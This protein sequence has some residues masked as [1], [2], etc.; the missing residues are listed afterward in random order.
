MHILLLIG[1]IAECGSA[2]K[3]LG[4]INTRS[5][6]TNRCI[7]IHLYLFTHSNYPK[8]TDLSRSPRL[9]GYSYPKGN[10]IDHVSI[11]HCTHIMLYWL[12]IQPA[13]TQTRHCKLVNDQNTAVLGTKTKAIAS[14]LLLHKLQKPNP[15]KHF[16]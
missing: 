15:V 12:C 5:C 7:L 6:S 8:Q 2:S 1:R 4:R 16:S 9:T 11:S 14:T 3:N 13:T 10:I